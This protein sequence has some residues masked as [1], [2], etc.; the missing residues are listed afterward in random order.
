MSAFRSQQLLEAIKIA[1]AEAEK[2]EI[3]GDRFRVGAV[4]LDENEQVVSTG[5]TGE[6]GHTDHAE[7]AALGKLS[8]QHAHTI[9]TTLEPCG[10]RGTK[11]QACIDLIKD[12]GIKQVYY[13]Q[14][15]PAHFVTNDRAKICAREN[16]IAYTYLPGYAHRVI[17]QNKH[18]NAEWPPYIALSFAM[19]AD[20]YL[21]DNSPERLIISSPEDMEDMRQERSYYDAI[22]VGAETIRRDNPRLILTDQAAINA[23]TQRDQAEH[24]TKITLTRSGALDPQSL[25]FT[26]GGK[27]FVLCP[28]GKVEHTLKERLKSA[29]DTTVATFPAQTI[30]PGDLRAFCTQHNL[31]SLFIEGGAQILNMFLKDGAFDMARVARSKSPLGKNGNGAIKHALDSKFLSLNTKKLGKTLT[32]IYLN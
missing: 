14:K 2:A 8:G 31:H 21:D 18:L 1:L 24:L 15:E 29:P 12:A 32:T 23:R 6:T 10:K 9:V 30:T 20:G 19:T 17:E 11:A 16:G 26:T 7:E 25:F 3:N 28:A 4:I 27:K 22:L 13:L 5:F